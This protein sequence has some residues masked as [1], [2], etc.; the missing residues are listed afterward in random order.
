VIHVLVITAVEE[1]EL[2][3]AVSGIVGGINIEQDL[4]PLASLF[5]ADIHK[6]IEQGILQLEEI[7]RRRRVLPAAVSRF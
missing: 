1:T 2:L 5:S 3:L 7:A 4:S 6:P